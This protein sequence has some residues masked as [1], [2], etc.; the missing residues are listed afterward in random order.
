[1][2]TNT[3]SNATAIATVTVLPVLIAISFVHLMNDSMQAAVVGLIP[4]LQESLHLTYAQLGW[5]L[6]MLNMTSSV[7]QPLV[8]TYTDRRSSPYML[9]L[10]MGMSFL[11]MVALA[12]SPNY[13]IVLISVVFIGL[14]SAIFHPEGSRVVYLA[15]GNKRGF[16]QSLYQVGGNLGGSLAPLMTIYIF[17]P[18]GQFGAM[19]GTLLAGAAI[20]VLLVLAPWYKRA[21]EAWS[22]A[23]EKRRAE[24]REGGS[25]LWIEA[26]HPRVK[27]AMTLVIFLIFVR[28]WYHSWLSGFF[29][30]YL[31][32][33]YGLT[34]E[35]AQIPVFLFLAAGVLGTF[36]GGVVADKVGIRNMIIF[37]I[38]GAAPLALLLPHL[39]L[40]W[41]YPVIV[42]LGFIILS[43]FSVMVVYAQFLMPS[44]VGM[45]SGL[46]TGLAFG[47]G[48]IGSVA[49]GRAADVFGLNDV[50]LVCS[51]LPLFGLLSFLLPSEKDGHPA[52]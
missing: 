19:W 33:N 5:V 12:L 8:G 35:Q 20:V 48:A 18:F 6:F 41:I 11:G 10:G 43:G 36:V 17:L 52:R 16:G 44:K 30:F 3:T 21:L 27:F 46:T 2:K 25:T 15:S 26:S 1:L 29:Q 13:W 45:A 38:A 24:S 49:L 50:M 34:T 28:S 37:S 31:R 7:M 9:P 4:I 39:P 32:D 22:E 51:G 42:L 40:V 23:R 14:G 47:L